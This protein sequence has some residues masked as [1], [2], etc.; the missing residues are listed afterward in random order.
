MIDS[1]EHRWIW[2]WAFFLLVLTTLPYWIGFSS[3][4]TDWR[5]TGFIFGVED[6]NSYIAKMLTGASGDWLF[7]TPYTATDQRGFL[8]FLPYLLLGKLT[9]GAGQ[10]VQMVALFQ[11]FRWAGI[12]LC[13]FATYDFLAIF[14]KDI[15]WRRWGLALATLG[16]GLG[17]VL[18]VIKSP[19]GLGTL[20][21]EFYSPETFGF[22]GLYGLPHL[23]FARALLLWGLRGFLLNGQGVSDEPQWK[24]I[25]RWAQPGIAWLVMGFMQ[26]VDVGIA[27]GVIGLYL[28]VRRFA[29][30][31]QEEQPEWLMDVRRTL[32]TGL[33][34][35]PILIYSGV[36]YLTDPFLKTWGAQNILPSPPFWQYLLAYGVVLPFAVIGGI[37]LIRSK[38]VES[39]M[40]VSWAIA[41]PV[42]AYLPVTIQRRLPEG[43]WV[44]LLALALAAFDLY[45]V[46]AGWQRTFYPLFVGAVLL[47]MGGCLSATQPDLPMFRPTVEVRAFEALRG[48][49]DS[50]DVVVASFDTSNA[51]PAWT[52]QRVVIGHG[53]E[54]V[55]LKENEATI[56]KMYSG[57][58]TQ[59]ERTAFFREY[60]VRF[61]WWGP[62]EQAIG[63]WNP[64]EAPD[65]H[66]V[67]HEGEYQ[68]FE[69][70]E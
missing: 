63:K 37:H 33:I 10:H 62:L 30:H 40:L 9:A 60:N 7:R 34:S 3:Q 2:G 58:L 68:I 54:S 25:W 41:L 48:V 17:W 14:L 24:K 32:V 61:L 29:W 39:L 22:L 59:E 31:R 35:A 21:L 38:R 4:G 6:G 66:S 15:R 5:F 46:R 56:S 1:S 12:V 64:Q 51:L 8:A 42:L 69:V 55:N 49:A 36:S 53:P 65:L 11:L 47:V 26:P 28:L 23:A 13:L 27:W 50:N 43:G 45:K 67:Y 16:G 18:A 70:V 20:P 19:E 57:E 52:P 44:A